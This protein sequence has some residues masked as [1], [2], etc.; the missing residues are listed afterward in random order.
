MIDIVEDKPKLGIPVKKVC[1]YDKKIISK[2][3]FE[4]KVFI[5][6]I[7]KRDEYRIRRIGR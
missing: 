5:L 6:K 7:E 1:S 3:E 4:N 2:E